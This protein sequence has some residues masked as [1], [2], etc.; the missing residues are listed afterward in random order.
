MADAEVDRV[1]EDVR[2]AITELH[3]TDNNG[4]VV[5]NYSENPNSGE[6]DN[7]ENILAKHPNEN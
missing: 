7:V 1:N 3:I 5:K 4:K 2:R 6:E